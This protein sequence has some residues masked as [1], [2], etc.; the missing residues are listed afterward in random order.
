MNR[1]SIIL[2]GALLLSIT[3]CA[4]SSVDQDFDAKLNTLQQTISVVVAQSNLDPEVAQDILDKANE[5]NQYAQ[6][7]IQQD[8]FEIRAASGISSILETVDTMLQTA[9]MADAH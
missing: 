5:L 2:S 4:H 3:Y 7:N 6:N 1:S 9:N 8:A